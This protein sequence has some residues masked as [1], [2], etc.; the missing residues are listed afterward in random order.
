[1]EVTINKRT[2]VGHLERESVSLSSQVSR[3]A[4]LLSTSYTCFLSMILTTQ[5]LHSVTWHILDPR[6]D[7][8]PKSGML[9]AVIVF[10]TLV[11]CPLLLNN[12]FMESLFEESLCLTLPSFSIPTALMASMV[13]VPAARTAILGL[14]VL[15]SAM[16]FFS[17]L[18][19]PRTADRYVKTKLI[20]EIYRFAIPTSQVM[21]CVWRWMNA[22]IDPSLSERYWYIKLIMGLFGYI[23]AFVTGA[24]FLVHESRVTPG[25]IL[26][27]MAKDPLP[28]AEEY[29]SVADP[30]INTSIGA[31]TWW[32][33]LLWLPAGISL[34]ST[35][36][37]STFV[38]SSVAQICRWNGL[39]P[40]E[41]GIYI[42]LALFFGTLARLMLSTRMRESD[43][44]VHAVDCALSTVFLCVGLL[45]FAYLGGDVVG[46]WAVLLAELAAASMWH[47]VLRLAEVRA[48][49]AHGGLTLVVSG[50]ATLSFWFLSLAAV[51]GG[52][53]P[54]GERHRPAS[55]GE[56]STCASLSLLAPLQGQPFVA[57]AL[58]T[59]GAMG[60][61][62]IHAA[63]S[64][65][66]ALRERA[67]AR[68]RRAA[69]AD[70]YVVDPNKTWDED[71]SEENQM[72][73]VANAGDKEF[74]PQVVDQKHEH[75]N[76]GPPRQQV[77]HPR[78]GFGV[79]LVVFFAVIGPGII[80]R[81]V[82]HGGGPEEISALEGEFITV[83]SWNINFGWSTEGMIN[84]HDISERIKQQHAGVVALQDANA[85]Q[86]PLGSSDLAGFLA[87]SLT[88]H[89]EPGLPTSEAGDTG[90]PL[91]SK[92]Q[93]LLS[94]SHVLPDATEAEVAA[95]GL[96]DSCQTCSS[97]YRT[98]TEARLLVGS[99][100]V[101]VLNT[102]LERAD[103]VVH[104]AHTAARIRYIEKIAN[105]TTT[106]ILVLG[107]LG[108]E[109]TN[110]LLDGEH[111]YI[112]DCV[113]VS[114]NASVCLSFS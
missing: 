21:L 24:S 39:D 72:L 51:F 19:Q 13:P 89:L 106:P 79:L 35:L 10:G 77:V 52:A 30:M 97:A 104:A 111:P 2:T 57:V 63:F 105:E 55:N 81:V 33:N 54:L 110:P 43:G 16:G 99:T 80:S 49:G 36:F 12:R 25:G 95:M 112:H 37:L 14:G 82:S 103:G 48:V 47:H 114:I 31:F 17:I 100:P 15:F 102:Q 20:F 68:A 98:I 44:L 45:L 34:G 70:R 61:P 73:A 29:D 92:Y 93:L 96:T 78:E 53:L 22:D 69:E 75:V 50:I 8:W 83:V 85:L 107:G 11:C 113:C 90:N 74:V 84:I 59:V 9:L 5:F 7:P 91:L 67:Q 108:I 86:W 41:H 76:A 109:P 26:A 46:F 62:L 101:T 56:C 88:M 64:S 60:G 71:D 23:S 42:V 18:C 66:R 58:A 1:M 6:E 27:D 40:Y 28:A 4:F 38:F 3:A 94:R 87:T 32:E 65:A